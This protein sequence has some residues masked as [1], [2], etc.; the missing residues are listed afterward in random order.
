MTDTY[1]INFD[2]AIADELKSRFRAD[3]SFLENLGFTFLNVF[4]ETM[5]PFSLIT[6]FPVYLIMK[7]SNEMIGIRPPLRVASYG[8]VF[9][10]PAYGTYVHVFGL[11]CKFYTGFTDG[12]WLVTNSNL[13]SGSDTIVI[14]NRLDAPE[15][16]EKVWQRHL[17]Q[18]E[19]MKTEGKIPDARLSFEAWAKID[20]KIDKANMRAV[21]QFGFL[22]TAFLVFVLY[23][24]L[25]W[26]F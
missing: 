3:I 20:R 23:S 18:A 21:K 14:Q 8:I 4:Q 15:P 24:L 22:W 25:K 2:K 12:T 11:G 7:L 13:K 19:K 5:W 16:T 26:L 9:A 1:E 17:A 6:F 10:S